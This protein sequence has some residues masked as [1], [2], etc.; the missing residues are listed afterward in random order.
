MADVVPQSQNDYFNSINDLLGGLGS[1]AERAV[2]IYSTFLG[3]RTAAQ[4]AQSQHAGLNNQPTTSDLNAI[5][6]SRL[7][8][9]DTLTYVAIGVAIMGTFALIYKAF[10]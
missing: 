5:N 1:A 3:A 7:K 10:K 9:L 2:G 8:N 6:M 4:L